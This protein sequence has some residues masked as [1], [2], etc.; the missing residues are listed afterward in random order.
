MLA[1]GITATDANIEKIGMDERDGRVSVVHLIISV[2]DRLHLSRVI[3][4]LRALK[5]VMHIQRIRN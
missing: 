4:K 5:G 1:T 2:R 3:K